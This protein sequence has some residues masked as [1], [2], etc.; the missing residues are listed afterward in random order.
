MNV[1]IVA[2]A[3]QFPEME[4]INGI[5]AAVRIRARSFLLYCSWRLVF[6]ICMIIPETI[7]AEE[8]FG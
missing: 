3:A 4:Y 7:L 1:E 2:E 8:I 6:Y 5:A